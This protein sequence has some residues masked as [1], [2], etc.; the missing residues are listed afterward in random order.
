MVCVYAISGVCVA[1]QLIPRHE[2]KQED[3]TCCFDWGLLVEPVTL[4]C[5]HTFCRHCVG[6][7]LDDAANKVRGL[8]SGLIM[9]R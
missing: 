3:D 9:N 2:N 4:L 8:V 5:G 6:I 7:M 1:H